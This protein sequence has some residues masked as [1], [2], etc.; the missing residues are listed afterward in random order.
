MSPSKR[1]DHDHFC[2]TCGFM[3]G[4]NPNPHWVDGSNSGHQDNI[5]AHTCKCGSEQWIKHY[6]QSYFLDTFPR[7]GMNG[8]LRHRALELNTH[9]KKDRLREQRETRENPMAELFEMLEKIER[10][11]V[12]S[13]GKQN[14]L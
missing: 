14:R 10:A 1:F 4:H 11:N 2:A 9:Q 13:R 7:E 12:A 3:W 5:K 6:E 8:Y